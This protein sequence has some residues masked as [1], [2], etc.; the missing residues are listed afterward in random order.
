[1]SDAPMPHALP[2]WP[3]LIPHWPKRAPHLRKSVSTINVNF[4]HVHLPDVAVDS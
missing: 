3:Q 4:K 2:I 1:M